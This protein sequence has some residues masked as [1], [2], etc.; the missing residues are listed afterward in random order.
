MQ[1]R[2]RTRAQAYLLYVGANA[3]RPDEA[4]G[5]LSEAEYAEDKSS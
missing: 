4:D 2:T 5:G 1:G 3:R